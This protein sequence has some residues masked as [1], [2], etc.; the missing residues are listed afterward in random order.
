Y[1]LTDY[2]NGN[3]LRK[4][5]I[6]IRTDKKGNRFIEDARCEKF[7]HGTTTKRGFAD[8]LLL[9]GLMRPQR[10][11]DPWTENRII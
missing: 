1:I 2:A 11:Y 8:F 6:A 7:S 10:S 3:K 4:T 9:D 5:G